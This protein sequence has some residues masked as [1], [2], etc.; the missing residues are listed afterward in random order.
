[1]N[2]Q[3]AISVQ[4]VSKKYQ[5]GKFKD[6]SLRGVMSNLLKSQGENFDEFFALKNISFDINKGDVVGVIGKNGAGKSTLLKILSQ[7]TKPSEGRIE[8]NGRIASL[9][10]VGTGFHPEL[11]GRE[12]VYLNGTILGM[13]RKEVKTK[14]DEIVEFS[15]VKKFID[16]PVKH[17]S[18]GM[19]VRLAFAVA[20]HLDPEI[21]IIDE[22]L[23]VGDAEFQKKCLGKM[24]DVA[25]QGRT[26]LFVSHNIGSVA[27]LCNRGILLAEGKLMKLDDISEVIKEYQLLGSKEKRVYEN[28]T[29][30]KEFFV[31]RAQLLNS[32]ND[33]YHTE[34][35]N[36]KFN[37]GNNKIVT[38]NNYLLIR[39]MDENDG[40]IFSSEIEIEKDRDE[41]NLEIPA[42]T[43]TKGSYSVN[44]IVY[45]P[46]I[47]QYDNVH[48]CCRFHILDNTPSFSHLEGFDIGKVYLNAEWV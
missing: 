14:F 26:V 28:N 4:K 48:S 30:T 44:C 10:E 36:F 33:F 45:H 42:A 37:I 17:Y 24:K 27:A 38:S 8:I 35:I 29:S 9:L 2:N 46:A 13:S 39:F 21:L 40:T 5:I 22:V 7:I 15:G 6:G 11:T 47:I 31:K 12:N 19:Y 20:A 18:S 3:T 25:N 1:M 34:K 41:Y 32:I 16:T 43:F 23:A